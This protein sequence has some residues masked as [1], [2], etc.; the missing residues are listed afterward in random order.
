LKTTLEGRDCYDPPATA[1]NDFIA[2]RTIGERAQQNPVRSPGNGR[3][4]SQ[5]VPGKFLEGL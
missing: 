4:I 1:T 5:R 2:G 3:E